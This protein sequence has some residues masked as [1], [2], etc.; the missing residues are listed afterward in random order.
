M[1]GPVGKQLACVQVEG[2]DPE[3]RRGE[4]PVPVQ[5]LGRRSGGSLGATG[6]GDVGLEVGNV[7]VQTGG[8]HGVV[9]PLA[10]LE[11]PW[12]AGA[13]A[14]PD[15]P[16]RR[17]GRERPDALDG[18]QE[19]LD[20][21]T[22]EAL[23]DPP[24]GPGVDIPEEAQ[25]HVKLGRAG[26][27]EPGERLGHRLQRGPDRIR[28]SKRNEEPLG[29]LAWRAVRHDWITPLNRIVG[30]ERMGPFQVV[31]PSL[32]KRPVGDLSKLDSGLRRDLSSRWLPLQRARLELQ[33][34]YGQRKRVKTKSN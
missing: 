1:P 11:K 6:K 15:C 8:K 16:G 26:P 18:K 9:Q 34:F 17:A 22:R 24:K 5:P 32:S 10:K 27:R 12:M 7:E 29:D 21:D 33:R 31:S 20:A 28:Q 2:V 23:V 30:K 4:I 19:G 14:G 25:G 3:G 13:R